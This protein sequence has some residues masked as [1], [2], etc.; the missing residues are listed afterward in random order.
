MRLRYY[1]RNYLEFVKLNVQTWAEY[2]LDFIIGIVAIFLTN[3]TAIVFYWVVFQHIPTLNGWSLNQLLFIFG[4]VAL[5][6]GIWHVF[7]TGCS[8]WSMDRLVRRGELDRYLLRPMNTLTLL[9][10]RN[11]DE[12]GFGDIAAG[13]MLLIYSSSKLG[14]I[15]TPQMI[16]AFAALM[17]GAVLVMFS[18]L[19]FLSS[20]AFWVTTVRSLMDMFWNAVKLAEYPLD[21]YSTMVVWI[22]TYIFPIGFIGFYPAQFFFQN[23]E[24]MAFAYATPLAGLALFAVAYTSW[25]YGLKNYTSTGH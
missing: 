7:L 16:L 6:G 3:V 11:I 19:L 2:R 5:T 21:I 17:G 14:L 9:I 20:I 4:F 25:R 18:I 23:S 13:A 8:P 15:W 12:D 24:W 1:L 10:M 22:L